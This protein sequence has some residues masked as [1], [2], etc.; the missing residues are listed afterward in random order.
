MALSSASPLDITSITEQRN[1][2]DPI[3]SPNI[4]VNSPVEMDPRLVTVAMFRQRREVQSPI[5]MPDGDS[6]LEWVTWKNSLPNNSVSFYNDYVGRTDYVCKYNRHAGFYSPSSGTYCHYA[7][8]GTEYTGYPFEILVNKDNF[9]ILEWKDDSYGSVPKN[10]VITSPGE[11]IYV[12]KNKYGLGKVDTHYKRLYLPWKGYEYSYNGYQVLTISENIVRQQIDNVRYIADELD[13]FKYPTEI[14]RVSTLKNLESHP[15]VRTDTLSQTYQVTQRWDFSFS[16][17]AGV[18]TTFTVGVPF[19][20]EGGI[21]ISFETT[22]QYSMG[23]TVTESV[24]DTVTVQLTAP[25]NTSCSVNMMRH[26]NKLT[27]PFTARLRR[28]YGNGEI[29]TTSITGTYSGVQVGKVEVVHDKCEPL[30]ISNH[31]HEM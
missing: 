22:F 20:A 11:N 26:K 18:K 7:D 17:T 13:K 8:A 3:G 24:T 9:E 25:P 2:S 15:A 30:D 29:H 14:M 1:E 4:T 21:E 6:F 23:N 10:S 12:G 28:T 19:I 5:V 31:E 16:I 27:I